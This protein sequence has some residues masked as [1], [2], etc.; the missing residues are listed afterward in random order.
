MEKFLA[1][2]KNGQEQLEAAR[3]IDRILDQEFTYENAPSH[4][5][6]AVMQDAKN[7][8]H[9]EKWY[10][11]LW[12]APSLRPAGGLFAAIIIGIGLG[13]FSPNIVIIEQGLDLDE[14]SLSDSVLEWEENNENS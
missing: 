10:K 12:Q 14:I 5:H 7:I 1:R 11:N 4:L 3:E 9:P 2:S 8:F 6:G 13:W